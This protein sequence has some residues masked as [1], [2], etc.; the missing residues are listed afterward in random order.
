MKMARANARSLMSA[1][2]GTVAAVPVPTSSSR[3]SC[4]LLL[5]RQLGSRDSLQTFVRNRQPALDRNAVGP[6]RK[7]ALSPPDGGE[8]CAQIACETLVEL[9]LVEIGRKVGRVV[10]V[11]LLTV[12][13]VSKS[14]KRALEPV[15]LGGEQLASSIGIHRATLPARSRRKSI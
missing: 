14:S 6:G 11:G 4:A 9:L 15:A 10:I 12:V 7:T 13:F 8:L 3:F 2:A 1:N 5:H